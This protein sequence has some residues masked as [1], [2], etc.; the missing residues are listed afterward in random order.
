MA[1]MR[2]DRLHLEWNGTGRTPLRTKLFALVTFF[3]LG[4]SLAL[5][6]RPAKADASPVAVEAKA[7]DR[8]RKVSEETRF[9]DLIY[10]GGF[11]FA[12]SDSRLKGVSGLRI[13][14]GGERFL[15]IT[16]TGDWFAGRIARD[17]A[18]RPVGF[19]DAILAPIIGLDGTALGGRK[20]R[21]D[22]EALT[23]WR[24]QAVVAFEHDPRILVF[25][26]LSEPWRSQPTR[27]TLP[28]PREELRVNQGLE[29]L[30]TAPVGS[31][32]PGSL[33]TIAEG[34]IDEAGNLFAALFGA[35]GGGVFKVRKDAKWNVSDGDFLP[36]G[37][38]LVL[39]RRYEGFFG[40][41]GIRIRR[42]AGETI[43]PGALV[44]GPIIFEASLEDEIDNM[45]GLSVWRDADDRIRLT[46]VSDDN[47]SLF[48]RNLLL[49]FLLA[50]DGE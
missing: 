13:L 45:E 18:G 28:V 34:S 25:D 48:Q 27:L 17:E 35:P 26:D 8:F 37:D 41:L 3:L 49:E 40:G 10:V 33:V 1:S 42:I 50:D 47:G 15:A 5:M 6:P 39:E 30:A 19:E 44:D 43:R 14:D 38:L 32:R 23:L 46:L 11:S 9:G 12:G 24:D 7:I 22:A 29:M 4:A 16:D 2:S 36:G 21:A 31:K 20:Y